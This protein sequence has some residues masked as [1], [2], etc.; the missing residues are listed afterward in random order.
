MVRGSSAVKH[1]VLKL[2]CAGD[3]CIEPF[4]IDEFKPPIEDRYLVIETGTLEAMAGTAIAVDEVP[5]CGISP[6]LYLFICTFIFDCQVVR[7][8]L[9]DGEFEINLKFML[10]LLDEFTTN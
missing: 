2:R 8:Y 10:T 1:H 7:G 3:G 6:D 9:G 4:A 5:V